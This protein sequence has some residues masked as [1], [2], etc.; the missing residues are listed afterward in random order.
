MKTKIII[1]IL[2]TAISKISIG[3]ITML[4]IDSLYLSKIEEFYKNAD[5]F[6]NNSWPGMT[7]SPICIFRKN[8]PAFLYNHPNPPETLKKVR[9]NLYMGTQA[10]LQILGATQAEING[11]STAINGYDLPSYSCAEEAFADLFHEMHHNYQFKSVVSI[12]KPDNPVTLLFYPENYKNDALK[13]AEHKLLYSLCF[14]DDEK[15]FKEL[16]SQINHIRVNRETIIGKKFIDYEKDVESLEGPAFYCQ[17]LYYKEYA[18]VNSA[19]KNNYIQKEFF[20]VLNTPYYGRDKLRYRY[21]TSGMAMCYILDKYKQNWKKEYYSSD[22]K[23]YDYCISQFNIEKTISPEIE[24]IEVDYALSKYHTQLLIDNHTKNINQFNNQKGI[25]VILNFKKTPQFRGFDP[26]NAEAIN[27]STV[28]HSTLL[29][30]KG[31]LNNELFITSWPVITHFTEQIWYV[32]NVILFIPEKE[33]DFSDS[34]R[35]VLK[36]E[37]LQINW[38][39]TIKY[40]SKN[41]VLFIC[42]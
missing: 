25:K 42:E 9:D 34:N 22:I 18:N 39:G 7:L 28:L 41:E 4:P 2:F 20:G 27:D 37:N 17:L 5:Q 31:D 24:D 33:I 40:K 19:L 14:C 11:V 8:G 29:K 16:L 10:E 30:L 21:L 23:L 1:L 38:E 36:N 15:E 35:I 3:Q 6:R 26:M 12:K 13:I 32:N